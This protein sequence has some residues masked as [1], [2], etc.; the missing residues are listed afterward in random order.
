MRTTA[1]TKHP[2]ITAV[3]G[4]ARKQRSI[5]LDSPEHD[6]REAVGARMLAPAE[7]EELI[8]TARVVGTPAGFKAAFAFGASVAAGYRADD[9]AGLRWSMMMT[10]A[11]PT[12]AEPV[13][14]EVTCLAINDGKTNEAGHLLWSGLGRRFPARHPADCGKGQGHCL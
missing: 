4:E 11:T 9:L 6:P 5:L 10:Q 7:L 1:L 8:D 13:P 14:M 2:L 3:S 12:P